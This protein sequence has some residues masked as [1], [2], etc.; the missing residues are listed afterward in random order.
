MKKVVGLAM[1]AFGVTLAVILGVA[2]GVLASIPVSLLMLAVTARRDEQAAWKQPSR[3]SPTIVVI[4]GGEPQ[5]LKV[6]WLAEASYLRSEP[7]ILDIVE[8]DADG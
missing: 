4:W 8:R 5:G 3:P 7:Q 2:C 1:I 6:P